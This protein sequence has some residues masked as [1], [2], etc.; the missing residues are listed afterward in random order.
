[1]DV[2]QISSV[3]SPH[4]FFLGGVF[5]SKNRLKAETDGL[6]PWLQACWE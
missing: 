4:R 3:L 1:M 5:S 6:R 2:W